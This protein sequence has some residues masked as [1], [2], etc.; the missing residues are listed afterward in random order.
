MPEAIV[1]PP[2]ISVLGRIMKK[3][4]LIVSSVLVVLLL[5]G[6]GTGLVLAYY[7]EPAF[8]RRC[9]IPPG[10]ERASASKQC[11]STLFT[12]L[13]NL[14]INAGTPDYTEPWSVPFGETEVN[15]FLQE[16]LFNKWK[17]LSSLQ[18]QGISDVRVAF[19]ADNHIRLGFRYGKEPWQ[20]IMSFDMRVWLV[21]KEMNVLAVE[22]VGRHAGALPVS[23][24]SLLTSIAEQLHSR[25][26][27]VSWYRHNGNPVALVR[28]QMDGA[29]PTVQL[30]EVAVRQGMLTIGGNPLE[31]GAQ[32]RR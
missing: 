28:F 23:A 20:T 14:I 30:R 5:S 3:R 17:D 8:Y 29:R 13:T 24:Q 22:L 10:P 12:K 4:N 27:E 31:L 32:A 16:D 18:Q 7:Y 21:P 9:E 26:V 15:S 2:F 25:F 6:L 11:F 19:E 1:P